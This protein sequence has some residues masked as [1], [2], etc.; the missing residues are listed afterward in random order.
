M[1]RNYWRK[2]PYEKILHQIP[3]LINKIK[4]TQNKF[5][6]MKAALGIMTTD[7]K[8]KLAMEECKIGNK[9]LKFME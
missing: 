3:N 9:K 5:I 6:W 2:F 4:Y 8:P 7:T 1:Y